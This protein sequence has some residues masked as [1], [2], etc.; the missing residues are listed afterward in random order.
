[1]LFA[2]I[3]ETPLRWSSMDHSKKLDRWKFGKIYPRANNL[4]DVRD[5]DGDGILIQMV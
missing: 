1:M 4:Y 5:G 3:E 2:R